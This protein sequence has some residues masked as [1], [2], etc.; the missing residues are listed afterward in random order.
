MAE[1]KYPS[2][3]RSDFEPNFEKREMDDQIDIGFAE[4]RFNDG[5][6]FRAES[7]SANQVKYL[8]YYFP[9]IDIK[10][11]ST[12]DLKQYLKSVHKIEF[13]DDN[14]QVGGYAGTNISAKRM[15]DASGNPIWEVTIVFGD[16]KK[17]YIR[18]GPKLQGYKRIR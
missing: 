4:G 8:T 18:Y 17:T 5:R 2:V 14:F 1:I 9:S 15:L 7:W 13:D 12:I 6:P 3:D 11:F 16:E 10:D